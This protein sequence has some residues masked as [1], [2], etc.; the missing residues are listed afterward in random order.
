MT[1]VP[2]PDEFIA[3]FPNATIPKIDG[4]P[5]YESLNNIRRLLKENAASVPSTL[6]GG[7]FG[8]LG[9]IVSAAT[10]TGIAP[11][12][13]YVTPANPGAIPPI[14]ATATQAQ[15]TVA[16][17]NHKE[18][19][20]LWREFQSLHT[21]LK[22]QLT[23]AIPE[24]YLRAIRNRHVGFA[25]RNIQ[26]IFNHLFTNYGNISPQD[27]V[28]NQERMMK[29]WNPEMPLENLIDQIEDCQEF[30]ES[31]GQPYTAAQILNSAYNLVFKTGL[32]FD[33]CRKWNAKPVAD[34]TW[35][36]FQTHFQQAQNQLREMQALGLK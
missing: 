2:T 1:S 7:I 16:E 35:T 17:R 33:D 13:P 22:S 30:A 4:Q 9:L 15:I 6:G 8:H 3:S 29:A 25:Q 36:N 23:N 14:A 11:D 20:R 12:T 27:I 26:E 34:K 31:A 5:D 19:L 21:A 32:Y 28:N 24:I 10:Y 18:N